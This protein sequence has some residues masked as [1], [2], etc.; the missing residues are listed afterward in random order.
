MRLILQTPYD[1]IS[2]LVTW[3]EMGPEFLIR[4]EA[5]ASMPQRLYSFVITYN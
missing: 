4:D 5:I 1:F 2:R 3:K